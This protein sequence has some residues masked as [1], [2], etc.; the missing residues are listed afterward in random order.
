MTSEHF[1]EVLEARRRQTALR[2]ASARQ[3]RSDGLGG[4]RANKVIN[5]SRSDHAVPR[6]SIVGVVWAG[7]PDSDPV[8]EGTPTED[9]LDEFG[10]GPNDYFLRVRGSSMKDAGIE[11]GDLVQVRPV[12]LG[13]A[14]PDGAIVLAEVDISQAVGERSGRTTIKRFFRQ[15]EKIRLQPANNSMNARDYQ[16][17]DVIIM[18]IIIN[19]IRQSAPL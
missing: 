7:D 5:M 13:T 3:R 19:I 6:G 18:G 8:M 15:G 4:S 14:P 2:K 11:E 12:R 17:D 9:L 10:V 16:S 1:L